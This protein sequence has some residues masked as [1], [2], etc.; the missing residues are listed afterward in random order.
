AL[1]LAAAA[2]V[3]AGC[4]VSSTLDP[5]ASAATK[6]QKAGAAHMTLRMTFDS[7]A[8]GGKPVTM[9]GTGVLDGD[10][11]ELTVDMSQLMRA[12]GAPSTAG[13]FH[14]I[15]LRENGDYVLYLQ[16]GLLEQLTGGKHWVKLDLSK[17]G[18]KLGIDFDKLMQG[19]ASQDPTQLL[20][21]L[22]ASAGRVQT[23]GTERLD[24]TAT[25]HYKA[26]V[27]LYDA[28]KVK[29]VSADAVQKLVDAGA[30][31]MIPEDVWVGADGLVRRLR[32]A[33]SMTTAGVPLRMTMQ[34]DLGDWGAAASIVAPPAADVLDASELR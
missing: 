31:I 3:A 17:A 8:L 10:R 30:P 15:F 13:R 2:A 11:G 20:A 12:S 33:Y 6:T 25:T 1:V 9:S 7:P 26:T 24:G 34:M 19:G 21:M 16:M 27:D 4:G 18:D 32:V 23:V 29:G 5:V 22:R 14:E 28:A